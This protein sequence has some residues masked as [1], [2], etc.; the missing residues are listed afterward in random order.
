MIRAEEAG[1]CYWKIGTTYLKDPVNVDKVHYIEC[2][3]KDLLGISSAREISRAIST[4]IRN[5]IK[6]IN[7][8]GHTLPKPSK[9]FS[10]DLPLNIL[11]EI[12]DFWLDIYSHPREWRKCIRLLKLRTTIESF[13]PIIIRGLIGSTSRWAAKIEQ[14]HSYRPEVSSPKKK[15]LKEHL[16]LR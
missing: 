16:N 13:D 15:L 1:E 2:F 12:Y 14:L 7:Q 10:Y 8:E 3:R 6:L 9:G 11:E 5:L 4:N